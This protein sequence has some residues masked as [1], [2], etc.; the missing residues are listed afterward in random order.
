MKFIINNI[1]KVIAEMTIKK[2]FKTLLFLAVFSGF[3][4]MNNTH[5]YKNAN[6]ENVPVTPDDLTLLKK[7]Y[8]KN[9]SP[10]DNVKQR[11]IIEKNKEQHDAIDKQ[12]ESVEGTIPELG[13]NAEEKAD[14]EDFRPEGGA[15]ITEDD[16]YVYYDDE[17]FEEEP[18]G[19]FSQATFFLKK[20][21]YLSSNLEKWANAVG[22]TLIYDAKKDLFIRQDV[23][24]DVSLKEGMDFIAKKVFPSD[25]YAEIYRANKTIIIKQRTVDN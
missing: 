18:M 6:G 13:E 16:V 15:V 5:E 17:E 8:T 22:W 12:K 11:N 2:A 4:I 24:L 19:L 20:G 1:K 10:A 9:K 7:L 25:M 3:F 21:E 14:K 23:A